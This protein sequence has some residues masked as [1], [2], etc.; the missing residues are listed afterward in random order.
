MPDIRQTQRP[1]SDHAT[2]GSANEGRADS[3]D[4]AS[5]AQS[6]A[7]GPK[8]SLLKR[9]SNLFTPTPGTHDALSGPL[10]AWRAFHPT[11]V[12]LHL[13]QDPHPETNANHR[14]LPEEHRAD[15]EAAQKMTLAQRQHLLQPPR[16]LRGP[17]PRN[18]AGEDGY[19]AA[20]SMT[21]HISEFRLSIDLNFLAPVERDVLHAMRRTR[22]SSHFRPLMNPTE[23]ILLVHESDYEVVRQ[24]QD[25]IRPLPAKEKC[26]LAADLYDFLKEEKRYMLKLLLFH[27]TICV[28]TKAR[29]QRL[30]MEEAEGPEDRTQ[31]F[32]SFA[33]NVTSL[34]SGGSAGG[35][36]SHET[37]TQVNTTFS[38]VSTSDFHTDTT[39]RHALVSNEQRLSNLLLKRY[40][41]YVVAAVARTARK[42]PAPT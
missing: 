17:I 36:M 3:T 31:N 7:K 9:I 11:H 40:R 38:S 5:Q 37:S 30:G 12:G 39:N 23:E 16:E 1:S 13:T 42:A 21:E 6:P 32:V 8:P 4:N 18:R 35:R 34:N 33:Q 28:T 2:D 20:R 10:P 15:H 19:V 27:P 22:P 41:S 25:W 24:I 14:K 26:T 29:G